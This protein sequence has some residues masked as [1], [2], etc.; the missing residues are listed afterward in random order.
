MDC[1]LPGS[2]V[3]GIFQARVLEWGAIDFSKMST[4][5]TQIDTVR[6]TYII[7]MVI[8]NQIC[9]TDTQKLKKKGKQAYSKENHQTTMEQKREARKNNYN[10][11]PLNLGNN[12]MEI[13][14][15]LSTNFFECQW[16]K[17]SNQNIAWLIG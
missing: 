9:T 11:H 14:T 15:Y 10:F 1:S 7:H 3:G 16:T 4:S 17:C 12:K 8:T 5:L 2:S 6:S 13:S